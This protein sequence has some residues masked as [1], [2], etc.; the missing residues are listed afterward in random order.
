MLCPFCKEE[1]QDGAIKCKHCGSMLVPLQRPQGENVVYIHKEKGSIG[2]AVASLI[3]GLASLP[4][5]IGT[6]KMD[7]DTVIGCIM[8]GLISIGLG[9]GSL[10]H[11]KRGR[12]MAITGIIFG[13]LELLAAIANL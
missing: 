2:F 4:L 8:L 9:I 10:D 13:S 11:T 5:W 1:I 7:K 6:E 12:G 3:I